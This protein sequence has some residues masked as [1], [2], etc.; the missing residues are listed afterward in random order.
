MSRAY[1]GRQRKHAKRRGGHKGHGGPSSGKEGYDIGRSFE[2]RVE[3]L[4]GRLVHSGV[5]DSFQYHKPNSRE[6]LKG[7]DF[8]VVLKGETRSFGVTTSSSRWKKTHVRN[9]ER[10][11]PNLLFSRKASDDCIT[12]RILELFKS[13]EGK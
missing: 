4:L 5:V 11:I 13:T 8:T 2:I 3:Q 7:K 10:G 6:D 1:R 12:E 9:L